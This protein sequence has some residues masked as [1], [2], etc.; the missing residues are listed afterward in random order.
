MTRKGA[1]MIIET[2]SLRVF[3]IQ[4][5]KERLTKEEEGHRARIFEL[6]QFQEP[7]Q[8]QPIVSVG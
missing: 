8:P 3:E 7:I 4:E 2:L 1:Q 6:E 5:M